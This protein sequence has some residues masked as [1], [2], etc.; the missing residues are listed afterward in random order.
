MCYRIRMNMEEPPDLY[1]PPPRGQRSS[2]GHAATT[3]SRGP[4]LA[5]LVM[6]SLLLGAAISW[7]WSHQQRNHSLRGTL[8]IVQ[9][10]LTLMQ[11]HQADAVLLL[12][13]AETQLLAFAPAHVTAE[14]RPAL[15]VAW[16]P[17][18]QRGLLLAG[19]MPLLSSGQVYMLREVSAGT[20]E[21]APIALIDPQAGEIARLFHVNASR[22]VREFRIS[23]EPRQGDPAAPPIYT[24]RVQ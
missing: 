6:L 14:G 16:N 23:E 15:A 5:P 17:R 8:S 20:E 9:A 2:S 19:R 11:A 10:D 1:R 12:G 4:S 24:A 18:M 21:A 22:A 13:D 7:G 3:G